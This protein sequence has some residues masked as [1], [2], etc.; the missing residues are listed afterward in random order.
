MTR[1]RD[2]IHRVTTPLRRRYYMRGTASA[3]V[4]RLP[5]GVRRRL[6]LDDHVALG[7]RKIEVGGGPFPQ[8]GYI[9]VD[10]DGRAR[11]LEA[12]APAWQLPFPA[13]WAEEVLA[14][15]S[16]E[17][18]PPRMLLPTLREWRRVLVPGG[19]ARIH[20]PNA[21][22]LVQSFLDSPVEQKWRVA[23]ALLGQY[24][25]PTVSGPEDVD[26]AAD[27]QLMFDWPTLEWALESAGFREIR[28]LT[29]TVTDSHTTGW[30]DVVP[31]FS[32]IAEALR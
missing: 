1:M 17:H 23:S 22:E 7:S 20:V 27:H 15:H 18:V 13:D 3:G 4:T 5:R 21:P 11:H 16:L 10:I 31:N 26:A 32:L 14:I 30:S 6:G 28:N 2:G 9:H 24:S 25:N 29:G 12:F 19:R 8:P